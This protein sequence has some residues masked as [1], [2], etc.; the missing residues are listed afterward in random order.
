MDTLESM[1][2][3]VRVVETGSFTKA[4]ALAHLTTPQASRSINDLESRLRTRLLNRTTRRISL[5]EAGELY[6]QRCQQILSDVD[7]AEAEAA[8]ATGQPSGRIR[9]HGT[10]SFGQHYL[11]PLIARYSERFPD[12]RFDLVLAQR[13]PDL[14]EEGFD[15]SIVVAT[16]LADSALISQRLGAIHTVLCTS[17][18]YVSRRGLP[19]SVE[20]LARHTCL[21]LELPDVPHGHWLFDGADGEVFQHPASTHLSVNVAEALAEAIREGMGIG[22]LPVPV[23]LGGLRDGTLVRVLPQHRLRASNVFALYASRRYLDAKIRTFVEFLR[24]AVPPAIA[25]RERELAHLATAPH[26]RRPALR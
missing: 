26:P 3:F 18:Q 21:L 24:D 20:E 1:R 7:L 22:P 10:T 14:V 25:E 19:A 2:M 6:L 17:P 9:V 4:A 15:V 8:G 12:V 23:A 13:A 11:A 5:T 16:A